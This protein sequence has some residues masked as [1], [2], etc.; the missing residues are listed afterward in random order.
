ML[1][2]AGGSGM[3]PLWSML[4]YMREKKIN[5]PVCYFFGAITQKDLFL[6]DELN[7]LQK[8]LP[9]FRFIPALSNEPTDST[10][11]G[12]RGLITD[13][14]ARHFPTCTDS[15]AYLCGSPGMINACIKMLKNGGMPESNI[16]FD[17]FA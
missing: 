7:A 5:R 1:M 12:E 10:W 2:I 14:V 17:K 9:N 8:D 15:E 13:V 16:F 6:I 11:Q 3:A 4:R